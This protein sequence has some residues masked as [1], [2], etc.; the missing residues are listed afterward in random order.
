M[1]WIADFRELAEIAKIVRRNLPYLREGLELAEELRKRSGRDA[2]QGDLDADVAKL[3]ELDR[4][5]RTR[6]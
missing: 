4:K 1:G 3:R 2:A 5:R 6:R